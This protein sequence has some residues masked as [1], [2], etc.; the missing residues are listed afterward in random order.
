M[1]FQHVSRIIK[2]T[3]EKILKEYLFTFNEK[4]NLNVLI[5]KL[6]I[7]IIF[8]CKKPVLTLYRIANRTLLTC[9]TNRIR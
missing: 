2:N 7:Q 1:S 8:L 9:Y 4:N 6:N 5:Y 3:L